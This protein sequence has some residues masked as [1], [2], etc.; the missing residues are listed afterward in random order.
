MA[1]LNLRNVRKVQL[2]SCE[3]YTDDTAF[4][5]NLIYRYENDDG[6]YD[7]H[8]PK[9]RLNSVLLA[10]GLPHL[11]TANNECVMSIAAK[12]VVLEKYNVYSHDSS[13]KP[14]TYENVPFVIETVEE[15]KPVEMTLEE[16]EKKLG[17]KVSIVS[18]GDKK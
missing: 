6:V 1:A 9:L 17:H 8:I 2:Y 11:R 3:L 5:L 12:D 13:G 18:K 16:I 10:Y 15:K 7:L 14:V 4:Y